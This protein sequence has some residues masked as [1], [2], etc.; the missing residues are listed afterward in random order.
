MALSGCVFRSAAFS[1]REMA[2]GLARMAVV[3]RYRDIM[4]GRP[5]R[6]RANDSAAVLIVVESKKS[7]WCGAA[8][9]LG[10]DINLVVTGCRIVVGRQNKG[11]TAQMGSIY[12]FFAHP[13]IPHRS[14][15]Y[16]RESED[17]VLWWEVV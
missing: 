6:V 13:R 10:L 3:D 2:V 9:R 4:L 12:D 5:R 17:R 7:G 14:S 15:P 11:T 16:C 1:A 8:K